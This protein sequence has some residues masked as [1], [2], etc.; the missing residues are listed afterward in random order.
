MRRRVD[1]PSA[2]R[3]TP[4]QRIHAARERFD[5]YKG[6]GTVIRRIGLEVIDLMLAGRRADELD[7]VE[8]SVLLRG[9]NWAGLYEDEYALAICAVRKWGSGFTAALTSAHYNA[10]WWPGDKFLEEA[11]RLIAEG[12]GDRAHWHVQKAWFLS[13]VA[14]G[15]RDKEEE[16]LPGDPIVDM[17][18]L[19]SAATEL[20]A[21][22]SVGIPD[23]SPELEHWNE[24]FK[25]LLSQPSCAHLKRPGGES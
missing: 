13:M 3:M 5:S 2:P 10:F 14:T 9:Y 16:W 12:V 4:E 19:R 23:S 17:E 11:D 8:T 21:A 1:G 18:A 22:L 20:E 15:E 6:P 25:C 7:P 24:T